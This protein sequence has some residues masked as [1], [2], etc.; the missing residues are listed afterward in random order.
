MA[1]LKIGFIGTGRK[2]ER[3]G[4]MGYAMCYQHADAYAK[5]DTCQMTA[6]ADIVEANAK[7]F[8]DQYGIEAIYLDYHEMLA[9]ESL[10]VVS[11]CT[12]PHLHA[13]MAIAC[14]QAGVKVCHCEKPM[15][16]TYGGSRRMLQVADQ[17]GMALSFNHQRRYGKPFRK[18]K[19]L[20]DSSGIGEV[21]RLEAAI[22][23]LYDGGTHW[24]DMLNYFNG[25]V[26]AEWILGQ[27]DCRRERRAFGAPVETQGICQVKYRNGVYALFATGEAQ[28][29]LGVPFRIH[30]TTGVIELAWSPTPGPM[31]RYRAL[32]D[33][34]W[35]PVD[36]EGE[37][38]HGPGFID[39]AI[40]DV[41]DCHLSGR[42]CELCARH[43]LNATEIIFGCYESS[44]ARK[45]IDCPLDVD[46]NPLVAMIDYGDVP[47][48]PAD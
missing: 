21:V 3:A 48:A 31:L 43:A 28:H 10:D 45:R 27:V 36:C 38:L 37:S 6:C 40:A 35:T 12:W 8:A 2:P 25:E 19:E 41:I 15:D 44:R 20:I 24:V 1:K 32:G 30:G 17:F 18:T 33:A 39:R 26:P 4:V 14:A 5:L 23:D 16:L 22:G 9:M 46:D 34:D 13:D 7:A 47:F 11:I 42:E 29:S